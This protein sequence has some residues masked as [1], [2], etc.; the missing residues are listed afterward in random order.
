MIITIRRSL[1]DRKDGRN[2][3]LSITSRDGTE[4]TLTFLS[5][6]DL[7][8]LRDTAAVF[9]AGQELPG[10]EEARQRKATG[11]PGGTQ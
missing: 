1:T 4:G 2:V 8:S 7:I 3:A 5:L 11:L 10:A 9:I 6:D